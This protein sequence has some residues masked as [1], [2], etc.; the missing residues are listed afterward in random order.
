MGVEYEQ[1]IERLEKIIENWFDKEELLKCL[2]NPEHGLCE[3]VTY[4]LEEGEA[5]Y[6]RDSILYNGIRSW[7]YFSGS[8]DPEAIL[9][10]VDGV[11]E[12]CRGF[13]ELYSN[14]KRLHLAVHLLQY[15]KTNGI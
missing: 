4:Y 8:F 10:P 5:I 11:E 3:N 15:L 12:Y 14:P 6:K 1:V 7:I 9:L 2:F 13:L